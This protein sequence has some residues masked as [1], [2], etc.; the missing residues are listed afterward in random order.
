MEDTQFYS[1]V[2][3][4]ILL[5]EAAKINLHFPSR[6]K[7]IEKATYP[8]A[9]TL[10]PTA[11]LFE[12]VAIFDFASLYANIVMAYNISPETLLDDNYEGSCIISPLSKTKFM[13][14]SD[15][16]G[17]VPALLIKY[18]KM[19]KELQTELNKIDKKSNEYVIKHLR[20]DATKVL[21]LTA[22]GIFGSAYS[23]YFNLKVASTITEVGRYLLQNVSDNLNK[24]NFKVLAGDTDSLFVKVNNFENIR[25]VD[26]LI[27]EYLST[28]DSSVKKELFDMKF[29]KYLKKIILTAKNE[30]EG[31]KKKYVSRCIN[32]GGQECD[33]IYSRG[34][35][36]GKK[37]TTM[38]CKRLLNELI[39][40]IL[41]K[42][43]TKENCIEIVEKYK[44]Y[45]LNDKVDVEDLI[46]T[47]RVSKMIDKYKNPSAHVKLAFDR[48]QKGERFY[49]GQ[50]IPY[51]VMK[52]S[53]LE[54]V[55]FKDYSGNFD[56]RYYWNNQIFPPAQRILESV[57]KE[58]DWEQY[59]EKI[60]KQKKLKLK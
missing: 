13:N 54:I 7:D 33:F 50:Q 42:E 30:T 40:L 23:R 55:H 21:I 47:K 5:K 18:T 32:D 44:L 53:P 19:K 46:I 29:E 27:K 9:L 58:H 48:V 2:V 24:N 16:I 15:K 25:V 22:Y 38:C 8:G 12:D 14:F 4:L 37:D 26:K 31:A 39:N 3:D 57:F 28:L 52:N 43:A 60:E 11:G 45:I 59:L 35:E 10:Q 41:Y 49:V 6:Q 1:R 20:R 51:V 36:L 34:S 17:F 56:R